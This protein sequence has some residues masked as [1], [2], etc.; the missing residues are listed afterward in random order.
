MR[1]PAFNVSAVVFKNETNFCLQ[2]MFHDDDSASAC[3]LIYYSFVS[4]HKDDLIFLK[5]W[6]TNRVQR[7]AYNCTLS[8]ALNSQPDR[9]A[10][11]VAIAVFAFSDEKHMIYGQPLN[12][13]YIMVDNELKTGNG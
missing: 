8:T 6:K 4:T 5:I 7:E 10:N 9:I 12:Y 13:T 1:Q 11:H 3:V 2:C